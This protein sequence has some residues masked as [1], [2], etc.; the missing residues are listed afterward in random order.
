MSIL[1]IFIFLVVV[2][3]GIFYWK[4]SEVDSY[5]EATQG[6]S[7]ITKLNTTKVYKKSIIFLGN[8]ASFFR[9]FLIA[10]LSLLL[11]LNLIVSVILGGLIE[12]ILILF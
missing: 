7:E 8:I 1:Y 11:I 12:L 9:K 5:L 4:K 10:A 3:A 6:V 2:Q